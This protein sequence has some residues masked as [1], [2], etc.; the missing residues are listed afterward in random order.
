MNDSAF[1]QNQALGRGVNIVGY[2]A[3]WEARRHARFQAKHF[4]LIREAGFD[5]VRVNLHPFRFMGEAPS[6]PIAPEWL[7]TL[8]WVVKQSLDNGLIAILDLHEFHAMAQQPERKKARFLAFWEQIAPLYK[9]AP[10]SI[11][12]EI[13]NEPFDELTP[14]LWNRYLAEA[15]ALI[16]RSNPD[17]T[18]I[19]GPGFW[20]GIEKL[21]ELVLPEEDRNIIAT[22]H[23]YHPMPFTHQGAPWAVEHKD[24]HGIEWHDTAEEQQAIAADFARAQV[25]SEKHRRPLYLGEFGAYEKA[26]MA[27]RAR[28]TARVARTAE[29]LGWSWGYWQFDSDFIVYDIDKDAWVEPLRDA[30]IPKDAA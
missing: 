6:Y 23:Y 20:N 21:D 3:L 17:R 26:D 22:V 30:L 16:R 24:Q 11:L 2:D 5:H 9:D 13:L 27:S 7:E 29:S 28:Y 19:I 1:T 14:E 8:D 25:W 15:H 18:L 12:F 4:R 10:D